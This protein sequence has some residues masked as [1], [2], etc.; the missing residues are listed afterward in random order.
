LSNQQQVALYSPYHMGEA[1][2]MP[3]ASD[4]TVR[5]RRRLWSPSS[6]VK[7]NFGALPGVTKGA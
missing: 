4:L 6:E 1:A 7:R 3:R 5:S 2:H